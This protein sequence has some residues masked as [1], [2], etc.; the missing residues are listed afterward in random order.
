MEAYTVKEERE[1]KRTKTQAG[2]RCSRA[3]R[4]SRPT[5]GRTAAD[6]VGGVAGEGDIE[7]I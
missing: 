2:L 3:F 1:T 6:I 5:A 4:V 7:E